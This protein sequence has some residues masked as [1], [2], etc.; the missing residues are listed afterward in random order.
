MASRLDVCPACGRELTEQRYGSGARD[1]GQFCSLDC[2][3]D[4]WYPN[5]T[6]KP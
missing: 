4:Y 5:Q 1:D 2:F 6:E 3:A